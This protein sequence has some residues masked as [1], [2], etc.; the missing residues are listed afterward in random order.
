MLHGTTGELMAGKKFADF[1][2]VL[3]KNTKPLYMRELN[4]NFPASSFMQLFLINNDPLDTLL[5]SQ[6]GEPRYKI[7]SCVDPHIEFPL[8][9]SP[10]YSSPS[11]SSSTDSRPHSFSSTSNLTSSSESLVLPAAAVI[12]ES[13][14]S[15]YMGHRQRPKG[16]HTAFPISRTHSNPHPDVHRN[17]QDPSSPHPSPILPPST[18]PSTLVTHIKRLDRRSF[19]QGKSETYVGRVEYSGDDV[20]TRVQLC[21]LGIELHGPP[22]CS[23]KSSED[24]TPVHTILTPKRNDAETALNAFRDFCTERQKPGTLPMNTNRGT[25]P[26]P[27]VLC[28]LTDFPILT[29]CRIWSFKG[30]DNRPYKWISLASNPILVNDTTPPTPLARYRPAKVGISS[31]GRRGFLEIQPEGLEREDWIVATFAAYF[32]MKLGNHQPSSE[33]QIPDSATVGLP[34]SMSMPIT[35][36]A[37]TAMSAQNTLSPPPPTQVPGRSP[38]KLSSSPAALAT[39]QALRRINKNYG[40]GSFSRPWWSFPSNSARLEF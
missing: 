1:W 30:P 6:D 28:L 8:S 18:S 37:K 14:P 32:R 15:P 29:C 40:C 19:N 33:T 21:H 9:S 4:T 36:F 16:I 12:I 27:Y 7:H 22:V 38:P 26:E 11:S 25:F 10:D 2:S 39:L 17:C 35:G 23:Q 24:S 20:G 31:R 34:I 5:V 3:T 13:E